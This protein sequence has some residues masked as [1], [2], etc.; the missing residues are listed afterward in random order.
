MERL[1]TQ[2]VAAAHGPAATLFGALTRAFGKVPNAYAT[3]G[4]NSPLALEAVL[5]LEGALARSALSAQER[6]IIK[7]T[8][9]AAAGCDYCVAA[10]TQ[11]GKKAGLGRDAMQAARNGGAIGDA[12]LDA[13]AQFV[14]ALQQGHGIAPRA[15]VTAV[16][17]VGFSDTQL[18]EALLTMASI[19]F[20]NLLNRVNDTVLDF[21]PAQ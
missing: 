17:A 16:Q 4:A 15:V 6:E 13:L 5:Q 3:V 1:H 12:R 20:T 21:P 10:H 7:L 14:R 19:T 11:L 2:P 9:S 8:V 18:V